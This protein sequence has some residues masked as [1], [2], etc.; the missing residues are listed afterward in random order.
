M[1]YSA[2]NEDDLVT[3]VNRL[4]GARALGIAIGLSLGSGALQD[5]SNE[6]AKGIRQPSRSPLTLGAVPMFGRLSRDM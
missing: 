1:S 5:I 3:L 2:L 4:F 6:N